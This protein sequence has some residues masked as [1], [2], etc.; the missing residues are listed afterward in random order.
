[1]SQPCDRGANVPAPGELDASLHEFWAENPWQIVAAGN[2]LSAF[3]RNRAFLNV[4]GQ[5][6][7]DISHLTGADSDGDGRAVVAADFRNV[8]QLD[9]MVRQAGGGPLLL[10]ENRLPRRHFLQVS[11][12]GTKSNRQGIGARITAEANGLTQT[13]EMYPVCSFLSQ[14]PNVVH[15]GLGDA[16]VVERLTIRWPSGRVQE[17]TGLRADRHIVVDEARDG[18]AAVSTVV[19]GKPMQP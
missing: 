5:D 13:R 10:F 6:F 17:L 12:R 3:E 14:A 9:L 16:P 15:F 1:V 4:K 2:N 7:L 11:L 19:P 8:G 18:D